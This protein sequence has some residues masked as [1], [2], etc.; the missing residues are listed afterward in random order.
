M[1]GDENFETCLLGNAGIVYEKRF[2]HDEIL[3]FE[4]CPNHSATF[5][6]HGSNDYI[7]DEI[8]RSLHDGLCVVKKIFECGTVVPGGGAVETSLAVFLENLAN[9]I[10]SKEKLA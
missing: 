2:G 10:T 6:L 7:L 9:S 3:I 4:N 5:I 8:D 1:E